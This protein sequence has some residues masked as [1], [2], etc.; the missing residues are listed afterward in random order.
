MTRGSAGVDGGS[1][2][3][4]GV[5]VEEEASTGRV[6]GAAVAV[7]RALGPGF[8][9]SVYHRALE[10][11]LDRR[12][13]PF[14]SEVEVDVTYVG[15]VVGRHRL[16]LIAIGGIV[17]ELKAVQS[18]DAV[19]F[20]QLRSYLKAAR[21][22]VGLLLNFASTRL[23]IRRV[24]H[25]TAQLRP[26]PNFPPFRHSLV[27]RSSAQNLDRPPRFCDDGPRLGRAYGGS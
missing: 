12:G 8:G 14:A 18:L 4:S 13:V 23:V 27:S 22:S 10:L 6:I 20:V 11:E 1:E 24:V 2:T 25:R 26:L 21:L 7:H 16:D 17:V 19:H 15:A 5:S 9:E 3:A